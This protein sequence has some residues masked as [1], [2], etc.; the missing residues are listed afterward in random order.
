MSGLKFTTS[1]FSKVAWYPTNYYVGDSVWNWW[2]KCKQIRNRNW[3]FEKLRVTFKLL[4]QNI[5]RR[6]RK[7]ETTD[8]KNMQS[9]NERKWLKSWI[10]GKLQRSCENFNLTRKLSNYQAL[11]LSIEKIHDNQCTNF[12]VYDCGQIQFDENSDECQWWTSNLAQIFVRND[13]ES[14]N[15]CLK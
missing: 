15:L 8:C 13:G 3:N 12:A 14:R 4:I 11:R 2:R 7:C 6:R 1:Y 10:S 5:R 9:K